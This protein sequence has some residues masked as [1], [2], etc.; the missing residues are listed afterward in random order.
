MCDSGG[1][2]DD[3]PTP[4]PAPAPPPAEEDPIYTMDPG[5]E[6]EW[7]A[8]NPDE[9][10]TF[11]SIPHHPAHDDDDGPTS[12][13]EPVYTPDPGEAPAADLPPLTEAEIASEYSE[14]TAAAEER[15]EELA[16][17]TDTTWTPDPGEDDSF[18]TDS[19]GSPVTDADGNPVIAGTHQGRDSDDSLVETEN[20]TAEEADEYG[21]GRNRRSFSD[22]RKGRLSIKRKNP[23]LA[24]G[25]KR[26]RSGL[27]ISR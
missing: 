6:Q 27:L 12:P 19:G 24:I 14:A 7:V 9:R 21:V 22:R 23:S 10:V 2:E 16:M 3:D 17:Y 26:Q 18:V 15:A 11:P 5:E 1:N 4:A 13:A 20:L 25:N 8:E